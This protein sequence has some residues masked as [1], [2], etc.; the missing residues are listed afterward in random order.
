M[1]AHQAQAY[2]D[3]SQPSE[4]DSYIA[5]CNH[6]ICIYLYTYMSLIYMSL[7]CN[8]TY[9]AIFS[10]FQS[11]LQLHILCRQVLDRMIY[12]GV[13]AKVVQK[14]I[15]TAAE[16]SIVVTGNRWQLMMIAMVVFRQLYKYIHIC[17]GKSY[18]MFS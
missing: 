15:R 9:I 4:I 11:H 17:R 12:G 13:G 1:L 14:V 18:R 6:F 2:Y 3:S 5:T 8:C 7:V 10:K 16:C